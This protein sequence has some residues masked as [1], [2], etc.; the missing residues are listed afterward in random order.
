VGS[1]Q[2]SYR[3]SGDSE[4]ARRDLAVVLERFSAWRDRLDR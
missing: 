4:A 2:D 3:T 1:V